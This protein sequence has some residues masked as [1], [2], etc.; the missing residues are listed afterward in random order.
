MRKGFC[1]TF[2]PASTTRG[3]APASTALRIQ[4]D[5]DAQ[6]GADDHGVSRPRPQLAPRSRPRLHDDD[7]A[8]ILSSLTSA[9]TMRSPQRPRP[10]CQP[11]STSSSPAAAASRRP[12]PRCQ[13]GDDPRLRADDQR[14]R[15]RCQ[16]PL[17]PDQRDDDGVGVSRIQPAY[18]FSL[19][20]WRSTGSSTSPPRGSAPTP[21][22]C[23]R[24]SWSRSGRAC[25]C[26]C[27]GCHF[28]RLDVRM[29]FAFA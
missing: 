11:T 1:G 17:Q 7:V 21:C 26:R 16:H 14:R 29:R 6:L 25:W 24:C 18:P 10:R 8:R 19:D 13:P 27:G 9:T 4:R 2:L 5:D 12:R 20:S 15:P 22:R 3:S 28:Q 23:W